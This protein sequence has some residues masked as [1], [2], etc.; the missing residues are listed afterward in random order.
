MN[1]RE[2]RRIGDFFGLKNFGVNLTRLAPGGWSA[3]MH[4]HSKQDE[5]IYVLKGEPTLV[6]ESGARP[7]APGM[8]AGFRCRLVRYES[9]FRRRLL[10][11]R[12]KDYW[13]LCRKCCGNTVEKW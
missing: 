1:K 2:K 8:C 12:V 4:A 11:S 13:V 7:L 5:L 6:T 3:L 9:G 10:S